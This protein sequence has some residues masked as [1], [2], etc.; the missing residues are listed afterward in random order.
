MKIHPFTIG[1]L[2]CLLCLAPVG[3]TDAQGYVNNATYEVTTAPKVQERVPV[4]NI[5]FMIGDGMGLHQLSS[6]WV[7]NKGKLFITTFPVTGLATTWCSDH[8]VTD[9]AAS[10]TALA[11][12]YKTTYGTVGLDPEGKPHPTLLETAKQQGKATGIVVT[13]SVCDATPAAFIAHVPSRN[14]KQDIALAYLTVMPDFVF[15]G[16]LQEFNRRRDGSDLIEKAKDFDYH[17]VTSPDKVGTDKHVYSKNMLIVANNDLPLADERG[18]VAQRALKMALAR[19]STNKK[20]FFLMVEGSSIDKRAHE[21]DLGGMIKEIYDFDK[22]VAI[23]REFAAKNPG[24]L[25][26]VTADH[27][28]S[29]V[30][31][32]KGD[33]AGGVINAQDTVGDHNGVVVPV[34]AYG[35]GASAFTG[36]YDNT[37]LSRKMLRCIA[38]KTDGK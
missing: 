37:E 34:Y 10:G 18:D 32:V 13:C 28:T 35:A 2:A 27:S 9:S 38:P 21:T 19:L 17:V 11:A 33:I 14:N 7:A 15:G 22:Q 36:F 5:I 16:G 24:T 12:G 30:N 1:F 29:N 25:V 6:A 31:I 4:K 20:G 3:A 26:V 8:L 23:A